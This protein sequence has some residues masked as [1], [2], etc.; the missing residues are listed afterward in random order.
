[1][2]TS[3]NNL[4]MT[5]LAFVGYGSFL[6]FCLIS[7][8]SSGQTA[9]S[10][11]T[12]MRISPGGTVTS[13]NNFTLNAGGSLSN[14]GTIMF[15]HNLT[16]LN[17]GETSLGPGTVV[18]TGIYNPT[19]TG[20]FVIENL[21]V[22]T[23]DPYNLYGVTLAGG[24]TTKVNGVLTLTHGCIDLGTNN[25]MLL[26]P[27]ATVAGT[28]S[29]ASMVIATGY[30][31]LM[32]RVSPASMSFT[33]P[34]GSGSQLIHKTYSPVSLYFSNSSSFGPN[35][36][37]GVNL[38]DAKY[39]GTDSSYLTRYWQLFSSDIY[40]FS[41][42]ASF[43]YPAE[44]VVGNESDIYSFRVSPAPFTAYNAAIASSHQMDIWELTSFGTF[45]G[46]MGNGYYPPAVRV[47]QNRY[48]H[49]Y[50][51]A[52]CADATQTLLI[53]SVEYTY[54]VYDGG[55]VTHIAGQNI[56]YLPGT[57]VNV[58]G[59]LHGYISTTFCNSYNSYGP[60][61]TTEG[62]GETENPPNLS[63]GNTIFKIYPNPTSGKFTLELK[64][65]HEKLQAQVEI[66]GILGER[67]MSK[68]M[69]LERK[70]EFS[71]A[72]RPVGVYVIHVTS[73]VNSET[74]KIIKQ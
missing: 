38:V 30:G 64:G 32:K 67:I 18:F 65:D 4:K 37:A 72:D 39:P 48:I 10:T 58:G 41:C 12:T 36:M 27:S 25:D 13:T 24:G 45:T 54:H 15:T 47:L 26:G 11:G 5:R 44:D 70:Q 52:L 35:S 60:A 49:S 21:T 66:V 19:I 73:G 51:G 3:L 55:N 34:V 62:T 68:D 56:R 17:G 31:H 46:N 53:G 33:F 16:T 9:I 28:P 2:K 29:A 71:L 59:Y 50:S 7:F 6:V 69:T 42:N 23:S 63:S 20:Q 22:N 14:E 8:A 57:I 1:M 61:Q 43:Q 40:S 74:Q